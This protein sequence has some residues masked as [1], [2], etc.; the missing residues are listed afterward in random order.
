MSENINRNTIYISIIIPMYNVEKFISKCI[1]SCLNQNNV[2]LGKEYE[3]IFVDDGSPDS[4]YLIASDLVNGKNGCHIIRQ[5]NR[6]LGGARNTGI[7]EAK[8]KY[9]WCVDSDD[10]ISPNAVKLLIDTILKYNLPDIVMFRSANVIESKITVRQNPFKLE[11]FPS[12]GILQFEK[13]RL[14]AC[15]PFHL[16][17]KSVLTENN[18]N[19]VEKLYHEDNEFMPRVAFN[20]KSVVGVND[21]LYF[22]YQN[23]ESISRTPNYKRAFDLILVANNLGR[24]ADTH[25]K[26]KSEKKMYEF[27]CISLNQAFNV[28]INQPRD[29]QERFLLAIKNNSSIIDY[30]NSSGN[31]F[32]RL[33]GYLIKI[34]PNYLTIYTILHNLKSS[35]VKCNVFLNKWLLGKLMN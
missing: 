12:S 3:I 28:M 16:I 4:S 20:S 11:E 7:S 17:K 23:P 10:W 26:G 8:G 13:N 25:L 24:F 15:V 2:C 14:R 34:M 27:I 1:E 31:L 22:V 33:E 6:G 21:I 32:Y 9:I 35:V 30:Y 19:F 18:I 29:L 5:E